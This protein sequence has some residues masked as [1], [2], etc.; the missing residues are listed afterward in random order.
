MKKDGIFRNREEYKRIKQMDR[1][2]MEDTIAGYMEKAY[3]EGFTMGRQC[4][5]KPSEVAVA[6][7]NIPGIGVKKRESIMEE[8]TKM[9]EERRKGELGNAC[10]IAGDV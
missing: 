8:V 7:S 6:I 1:N 4:G 10:N 5:V 2:T 9:Y 3:R